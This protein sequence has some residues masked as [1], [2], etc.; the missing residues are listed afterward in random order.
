MTSVFGTSMVTFKYEITVTLILTKEGE[1]MSNSINRGVKYVSLGLLV[2]LLLI[3]VVLLLA[4]LYTSYN[5]SMSLPKA[6]ATMEAVVAKAE[7]ALSVAQT[8]EAKVRAQ[9]DALQTP[10]ARAETAVAAAETAVAAAETTAVASIA[11]TS[12]TPTTT[13][14]LEP[15]LLDVVWVAI[16]YQAPDGSDGK[17]FYRVDSVQFYPLYDTD[18][19]KGTWPSATVQLALVVI[20]EHEEWQLCYPETARPVAESIATGFSGWGE[21][22]FVAE[23]ERTG[24]V[25]SGAVGE[26][27]LVAADLYFREWPKQTIIT[28]TA[29]VDSDG[30]GDLTI[31]DFEDDLSRRYLPPGVTRKLLL[32][33]TVAGEPKYTLVIIDPNSPSPGDEQAWWC[34]ICSICCRW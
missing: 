27:G 23:P 9:A 31:S 2:L 13:P 34:T 15:I 21:Y 5:F 30:D 6:T 18:T 11:V 8:S 7:S 17:V 22:L 4:L 24:G 19:I 10:I 32:A 1:K 3:L 14:N 16:T 29:F 20:P 25:E 26:P 12:A 33:E 28:S